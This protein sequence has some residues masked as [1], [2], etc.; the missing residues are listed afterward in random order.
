VSWCVTYEFVNPLFVSSAL[1]G[2]P[3]LGVEFDYDAAGNLIGLRHQLEVASVDPAEVVR[4]SE[5]DTRVLFEAIEFVY[6]LPAQVATQRA[7]NLGSAEDVTTGFASISGGAAIVAPI[8]FPSEAALAGA[9][10]RLAVRLHLSNLARSSAADSVAVYLY[11]LIW[12]DMR[13]RPGPADL[14]TSQE[15]LKFT[16]DFVSHGE[17]LSNVAA[18]NFVAAHTV[19]PIVAFDPTRDDHVA[20]VAAQRAEARALIEAEL[21]GVL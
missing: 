20:F 7:E 13:G 18:V 5:R 4:T 3:S 9:P 6:G 1:A 16:R 10:T 8:V 17:A 12:E 14:G 11:Y 19:G 2:Y 15:R 21:R